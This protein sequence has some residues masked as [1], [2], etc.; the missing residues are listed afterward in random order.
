MALF[1]LPSSGP[2]AL[3]PAVI[4]ALTFVAYLLAARAG[5]LLAIPPSNA[6]P[7]FPAAGLGMVCASTRAA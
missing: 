6:S 3:A 2:A 4:I 5:L 7:L 1:R